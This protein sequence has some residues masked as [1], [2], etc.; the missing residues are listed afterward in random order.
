MLLSKAIGVS[1]AELE[2]EHKLKQIKTGD[3][4]KDKAVKGKWTT[5]SGEL[6]RSFHIDWQPGRRSGSYGSDLERS[7]KVELGGEI[8][9]KKKYLAIPT[10]H[11]PKK[12]WAR[13]VHGLFFVK[14]RKGNLVLAQEAGASIKVMYVL[15]KKVKLPPRPALE[16]AVKATEE[17]RE[18]RFSNIVER[19][20][21]GRN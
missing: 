8:K 6:R 12:V 7:A 17:K 9:A 11:A 19:E 2:R 4:S 10:E 20:I 16:R 18:R 21:W 15:K 3:N 1:L 13:Y 14:T 5:R